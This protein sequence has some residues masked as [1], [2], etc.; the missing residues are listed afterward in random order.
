MGCKKS[1]SKGKQKQARYR[2]ADCGAVVQ[3]KSDVCDPKKMKK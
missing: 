2:C 3:K 1:A